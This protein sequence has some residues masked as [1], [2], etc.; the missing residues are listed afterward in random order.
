MKYHA[1]KRYLKS[2]EGKDY[3]KYIKQ[4][5]ACTRGIRKAK[6]KHEEN[7]AKGCKENPS[8]FLNYVNDKC[9]RW[10]SQTDISNLSTISSKGLI[11]L[12]NN[13]ILKGKFM[14]FKT[15]EFQ[16]NLVIFGQLV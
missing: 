7:V 1:Y 2:K 4:R 5:N 3:E 10:Q 6:K 14:L 13:H 9:T 11:S 12:L 16:P 15:L 8:K